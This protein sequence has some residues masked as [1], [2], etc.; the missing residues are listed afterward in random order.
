MKKPDGHLNREEFLAEAGEI[1][2]TLGEEL[3]QAEAEASEG[4]I[5]APRVNALFRGVHTLKGI[6]GLLGSGELVE[7]AHDLEEFLDRLRM[8]HT[9]LD[10][11]TLDLLYEAHETLEKLLAGVTVDERVRRRL[12]GQLRGEK[13]G[14][15]RADKE[16][17]GSPGIDPQLVNALTQY[18]EHRLRES[19]ASGAEVWLVE[20]SLDL[21][22]FDGELRTLIASLNEGGEVIGTLPSYTGGDNGL[23]FLLLYASRE[24]ADRVLE[25]AGPDV[26][27]HP[28]G[29]MPH[30]S[31]A[32]PGHVPSPAADGPPTPPEEV[33]P[34]GDRWLGERRSSLRV[35]L[36]RLDRLMNNVGELIVSRQRLTTL[37]RQLG[38]NSETRGVAGDLARAIQELGKK[39]D[40]LQR[41]VIGARMVPVGQIVGRLSRLVRKLSRA[42]GKEVRFRAEGERTE[43]DKVMIDRLLSP[44]VHLVRNAVD[45][46]IEPAEDRRRAGKPAVG[47]LLLKASQRGNSVVLTFS[48]DGRGI[49]L[50]RI[51]DEA[52]AQGLLDPHAEIGANEVSDLIF[53]PGFSTAPRVSEV[54]GRGVGLDVVRREIAA[55][56]GSIR[57]KT[58]PGA[59]TAFEIELPITLAIM[60]SVLARSAGQVFAIPVSAVTETLRLRGDRLDTVIREQVVRLRGETLPMVILSDYFRLADGKGPRP[61]YVLILRTAERVLA[62]GVEEVLGQQEVV[63]KGIGRRL[64]NIPGLAG[65]TEIGENQAALVIDPTSLAGEVC[66]ARG[67][68]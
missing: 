51:R 3:R 29:S 58:S 68:A 17:T 49:Q 66:H 43:L 9:L 41:S 35:N 45:H 65:A 44:L 52:L 62:L 1:L 25:R 11:G 34:E 4:E 7:T 60:Q 6:A 20:V 13:S 61:E 42:A 22:T 67:P 21:E 39:L 8:G 24:D 37:V 14:A 2:E 56:G 55:L 63:I 40:D 15:A 54:S 10:D 50:Q 30:G 48:D 57:V 47:T 12:S 33:E 26:K 64:E 23:C 19:L 38:E 32:G 28:A 59:G 36:E 31:V 5:A 53:A 16:K 27:V 18:E 46:G